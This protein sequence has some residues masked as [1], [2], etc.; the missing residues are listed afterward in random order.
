MKEISQMRAIRIA[1]LLGIASHSGFGFPQLSSWHKK[2][3]S[4]YARLFESTAD[5][6]SGASVTTWSRGAGVQSL[7][8]YAGV[9]QIS[10]S[11]N[12][13]Y[14]RS[15]GLAGHIMGPWYLDEGKSTDFPS[16][17]SN[18]AK[19]Y[20]IP[21]T[22]VI[23]EVK[24]STGLG[25]TGC[26]VN[27]VSMFD[28]RDAFSYVSASSMDATPVNGL[29]GD[30]VWNRDAYHNEKVTFDP[31]YAHQAMNNYHYHAQ[32]IGLRY[33][34][35]DHV[36]YDVVTNRYTEST[37]EVTQHSP[38]LAWAADGLP[39][40]GPYGYSDPLNPA[41]GIRRMVSGFVLR[42]GSYGTTN[43][44][45]TGRE[46][47]PAWAQRIQDTAFQSGPA[48]S[49][50]YQLGHY[51]EDFDYLGDHG[52]LQ[53]KDFDLNEQNVRWCVTPDFLEGTWAYFTTIKE[54]GT[55]A[56]PYTTG[57][58]YFG[59]PTG[60]EST[61][62]EAVTIYWNG[63]PNLTESLEAIETK[64]GD[65]VTITWNV[66]EG[67]GYQVEASG[68]LE[69]WEE[70]QNTTAEGGALVS[71]DSE[72]HPSGSPRFYRISRTNLAPFDSSGY[73]LGGGNT[74]N[75]GGTGSA[76]YVFQFSTTPPLPPDSN[77]VSIT[78]AGI[79]ADI[80]QYNGTTGAITVT[81]DDSTLASGTSYPATL[82]FS[83]PGQGAIV[84][85][86]TNSYPVP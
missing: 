4:N 3:A 80:T 24:T 15:S 21:R 31:A 11:A 41:S 63:G 10:Y 46:S 20:R 50:A 42:D 28:M 72:E 16:F 18:L 52:Y 14:I 12:W 9:N 49:A 40:Y 38:I 17:P 2:D 65:Q 75:T 73:D 6:A 84:K 56:F 35:G 45:S 27:G 1:L 19:I 62:S 29:R 13:V 82:S 59:S 58:Q 70:I 47:L 37:A 44:A 8:T 32:P 69:S 71:T 23:P 26:M 39:V 85:T 77:P 7:P 5:E 67:G 60:G 33:Q 53:G 64:D 74:G 76:S 66:A 36:D 51:I 30:G 57:R 54:D 83:P 68:N 22:P 25:A 55:P 34:L 78:I 81:F 79:S 61:L 43:L 48:V 86:S